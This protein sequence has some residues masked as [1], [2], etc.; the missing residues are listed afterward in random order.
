MF[1]YII[2]LFGYIV[3]LEDFLLNPKAYEPFASYEINWPFCDVILMLVA[4]VLIAVAVLVQPQPKDLASFIRKPKTRR[5]GR[6]SKG[7]HAKKKSKP[8]AP[9]E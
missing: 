6:R 2:E 9:R 1:G 7:K 8:Q 4:F 3:D 5:I